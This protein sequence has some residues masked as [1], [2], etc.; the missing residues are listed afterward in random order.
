MKKF[1]IFINYAISISLMIIPAFLTQDYLFNALKYIDN[2]SIAYLISF[3]GYLLFLLIGIFI[4]TI[5]HES[6]HLVAGLISGYKFSSF[7]ILST[8]FVK[9]GDKVKIKKFSIPGTAGQCLMLPPPLD[10]QGKIPY[11]LYNWGGCIFNLIFAIIFILLAVIFK[12]SPFALSFFIMLASTG[13]VLLVNNGL[14]L[15][16][17]LIQNDAQNVI[18]ISKSHK[19][20]QSFNIQLLVAECQSRGIK[21]QNMPEEWFIMPDDSEINNPIN[22]TIASLICSRE[23]ELGNFY[24][25]HKLIRSVL[26]KSPNMLGIYKTLLSL[27]IIYLDAIHQWASNEDILNRLFALNKQIAPLKRNITVQRVLYTTALLCEIN[28]QKAIKHLQ[29]FDSIAKKYPYPQEVENERKL[30]ALA[31]EAYKKISCIPQNSQN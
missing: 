29:L 4:N 24:N 14:P 6:G 18:D 19:A 27:E 8:C 11:K 7:R 12:S 20:I 22:A 17:A 10:S 3:L 25:A 30:I 23:I 16:T 15:G 5:I 9:D 1:K 2:S 31:Q 26:Q 21:L 28:L 13:L